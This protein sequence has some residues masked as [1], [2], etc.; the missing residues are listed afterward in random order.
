MADRE[1]VKEMQARWMNNHIGEE[2]EGTISSVT[3]Y[4]IFVTLPNTIEGCIGVANMANDEYSFDDKNKILIGVN[5]RKQFKLGESIKVRCIDAN[6][7][8]RTVF[9]EEVE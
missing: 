4:A 2:F 6:I 8:E 1:S 3:E 9:F 7:D 5:S